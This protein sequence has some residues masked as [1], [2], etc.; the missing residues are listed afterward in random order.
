MR[1]VRRQ[2]W[3][4]ALAVTPFGL[5]FGAAATEAGLTVW[6]ASCF[7]VFVFA[8]SAQFAAVEIIGQGGA[9]ISAI[10]AGLLLNLRSLAF[11]VAMAPSL[12]G[13]W[14]RRALWSQLMI[15]ETT[16]V[17]TS[18]PAGTQRRYGY[19]YAGVVLFSVWNL[20]TVVGAAA[21]PSGGDV[22]TDWG[23]DAA[24]PAAF[25][26]LLWPR[27]ANS[28]QRR[29]ALAGAAVALALVPLAPA[30]IPVI[31]A[32]AGVLFA[33]RAGPGRGSWSRRPSRER[34]PTGG[35]SR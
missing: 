27:L 29:T 35:E 1:A 23:I 30:G 2:A 17:G 16:A 11:G 26:A 12:K 28:D 19:L 31:A 4:I 8:G 15:D 33:G 10:A 5:A 25:L 21:L 34:V 3:S 22:V 24:I 18:L 13:S 6:E 7:S 9:A 20:S 32:A 14:W